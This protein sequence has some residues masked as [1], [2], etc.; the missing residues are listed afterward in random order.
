MVA[1]TL[2]VLLLI[3]EVDM[4]YGRVISGGERMVKGLSKGINDKLASYESSRAPIISM[5]Y[6]NTVN[7]EEDATVEDSIE[8]FLS[9]IRKS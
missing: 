1:M 8:D 3:S 6:V 9:A 4:S 5:E 7:R 2:T